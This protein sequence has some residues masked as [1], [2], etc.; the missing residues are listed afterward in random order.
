MTD[1]RKTAVY[2]RLSAEDDNVDGRA[3]KE[4]DSVTSQRILLKSFVID[5]LGV[6]EADILEY[7]DDGVSG[8]HFKRQGFQQLQDDMKSGEIGCVVVKD[9]SRFGRDYLEVGFYIEYI[10]P[11]LQIR[12]ISIND[13]YDSAASS[14]M[15]GGMNVALQNLVYNMYSLDLSKKISSALQ[16]RTRNGTRLPVNAR[17]GYKKGK[18]GRL[19]VDSEAAKVVKMIFRMAAEGTSFADITRELNR[20]AIATCDE[21]KLS[22]GDQVQFQRFDTIKKKHWSPT[23]VAAIVRDEIYIGT[24]IWGKTRCSMHTGHKAVLND[25]TASEMHPKKKRS[26]AE[27]RTNFTLERRK[28]QPAL[29]LCANCG[30]SLLKET[31]HLLKCS[32]ARTNGDP[33]CRS[34]VIRREPLEENILGL[35]HQYAASMLEKEK[36]VSSNRQCDDK[37]INTAELQK[38]SRQL[39]SEKMKLYDDYKDGRMDRDLYKQRAEKIS[40]QLDEIKR[41][42]EDAENSKKLLEQNE[43]SDKIK[44]KDFLGIQK[45]DTEKLREIIKVIRVHSQDEIEIEWNLDDIFSEQR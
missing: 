34:L 45:F 43:L 5:Q 26:V 30:H 17:Y 6:A 40:G 18:D 9:F 25:E 20:Q 41:K 19:E 22:R 12:F 38:Q 13:S 44:L 35:V 15:T 27:S 29:L 37:E 14:G 24:R 4:S 3:K 1:H 2:I 10:F 8:T 31:E 42:I 36:K 21:Q 7:V 32:D 39:T 11:L 23:T 28:K 16:T 33:V